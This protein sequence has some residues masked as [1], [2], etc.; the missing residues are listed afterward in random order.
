M[1]ARGL[2][3]VLTEKS[4]TERAFI[5]V[6][7]LPQP[8]ERYTETVCVAGIVPTG[9]WRRLYP[10]RFRQLKDSFQR[11][12]CIEYKWQLPRD[13]RRLESRNIE[14]DSVKVVSRLAQSERARFLKQRFRESTDEAASKQE[15]LAIIRP[16]KVSF[17][18]KP[19]TETEISEERE[20]YS[21]AAKQR[22][23]LEVDAEL[24]ALEPCPYKFFFKYQTADGRKHEN[25]CHDWETSAAFH[26]LSKTYG[27][28][29][30]LDHLNKEYNERYPKA[31]M[32][33][34]M[35]THSQ[36]PDQWLLIGVLRLDDQA[37]GELSV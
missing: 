24:K 11:W 28:E 13:D 30:A 25:F 36:R 5:L 22:S 35:G 33:F 6:K 9:Q 7:A 10:V 26:R 17:F 19:K 27:A 23:F 32:A 21:E 20:A 15:S 12:D 18:W 37:Q 31:G 8:S 16:E 3:N 1:Y 29:G 4:G 14:G 2:T 34:A